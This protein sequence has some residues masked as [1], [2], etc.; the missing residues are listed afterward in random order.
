M[1]NS[2]KVSSSQT[3]SWSC[4]LYI[5]CKVHEF[6]V[7]FEKQ[8]ALSYLCSSSRMDRITPDVD[9]FCCTVARKVNSLLFRNS[10]INFS[11]TWGAA[12]ISLSA[13]KGSR[14]RRRGKKKYRWEK[15]RGN[16]RRKRRKDIQL[17]MPC[18]QDPGSLSPL[19]FLSTV[20]IFRCRPPIHRAAR[21]Q[22]KAR[23]CCPGHRAHLSLWQVHNWPGSDFLTGILMGQGAIWP[24]ANRLGC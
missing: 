24:A 11:L 22:G 13:S 23:K 6:Q 14:R 9:G 7:D 20:S 1:F 8:T 2:R 5:L 16:T 17:K 10:W 3:F 12:W 21:T 19:P 4:T 15:R 18:P